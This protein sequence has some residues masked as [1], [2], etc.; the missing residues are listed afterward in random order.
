VRARS[1][2]FFIFFTV[3]TQQIFIELNWIRTGTKTPSKHLLLGMPHNSRAPAIGL[4]I[5]IPDFQAYFAVLE[6][7]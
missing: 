1:Y 3:S 5:L 2:S 6:I 4:A 7:K